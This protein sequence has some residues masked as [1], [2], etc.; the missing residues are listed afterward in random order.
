VTSVPGAFQSIA[1]TGTPVAAGSTALL[2]TGASCNN[3]VDNVDVAL[4]FS[5]TTPVGRAVK[6]GNTLYGTTANPLHVDSNGYVSLSTTTSTGTNAVLP[7]TTNPNGEFAV[8][9]DDLAAN[10]LTNSGVYWK[11][12]DP[13]GVANS[14]DEYTLI[15]WE[16]WKRSSTTDTSNLN[17]QM[18]ILE[19]TGSVEFHYG[20][21]TSS[22]TYYYNGAEATVWVESIDGTMA[23]PVSTNPWSINQAGMIP[24][25][26]GYRFTY[27]P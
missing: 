9:W 15:S 26:T 7:S 13:D 10:P 22:M 21:M 20:S 17:F 11:Q 19:A 25:N 8:W 5:R 2:S 24:A 16:N 6:I 23:L 12:F 3:C 1:A 27:S 4:D 18:K 14:G